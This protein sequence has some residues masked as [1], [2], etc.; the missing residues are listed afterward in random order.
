[1]KGKP[2]QLAGGQGTTYLAGTTVLKPLESEVEANWIINT[3]HQIEE[4]GFR[5][6]RYL[7]STNGTFLVDGWVAYEFLPGKR[8]KGRWK[9]KRA[10]LEDF[11][12]S[13]KAEPHPRFFDERMDCYS[14][15]DRMAWGE[16]AIKCHKRLVPAVK[17]LA[18]HIRPLRLPNQVIQGDSGNILFSRDAPPAIIDFSPYWRPVGFSLAVLIV[19]ALVWEGAS[20]SI[21]ESFSD[22]RYLD[23][24]L[25]RA[26]LRRILELDGLSRKYGMERLEE[27][28]AHMSTIEFISS[29]TS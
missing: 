21:I 1:V 11:H 22:V 16:L 9:E 25:L 20:D 5:V 26:E 10:V 29:I 15:A 7:A 3:L 14:L 13:L 6:P 18:S 12:L 27:V 4:K 24:L 2:R 19:D 17:K 28:N 23:Q 8:L